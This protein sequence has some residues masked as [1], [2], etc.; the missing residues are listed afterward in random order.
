MKHLYLYLYNV[1]SCYKNNRLRFRYSNA[2]KALSNLSRLTVYIIIKCKNHNQ[3]FFNS[4][5][6][7]IYDTMYYKIE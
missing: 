7:Y 2:L 4:I 1:F 5:G 3:C 6:F